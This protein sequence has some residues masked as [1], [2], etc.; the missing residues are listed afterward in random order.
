MTYAQQIQKWK[1]LVDLNGLNENWSARTKVLLSS[2]RI[3][4]LVDREMKD[5]IWEFLVPWVH[6]VPVKYDLSDLQDNYLMIE[7]DEKLQKYISE[8]QRKL[9]DIC[10]TRDAALKKIAFLIN[11]L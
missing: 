9:F 10:L 2:Q 1:Y 7:S 3:C 6:Y 4:F 5:W 11:E 8:N